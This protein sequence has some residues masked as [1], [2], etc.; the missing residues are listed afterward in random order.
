MTKAA[1]RTLPEM[2]RFSLSL[3]AA[4][5]PLR[6]SSYALA[7]KSLPPGPRRE[8]EALALGKYRRPALQVDYAEQDCA[9]EY[10]RLRSDVN[11]AKGM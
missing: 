8:P 11:R 2:R 5:L 10:C 4:P 6:K 3:K 9:G 1:K 7:M